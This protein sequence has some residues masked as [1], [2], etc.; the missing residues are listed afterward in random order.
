MNEMMIK[1]VAIAKPTDSG[2]I[3]DKVKRKSSVEI[4]TVSS[5]IT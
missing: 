2:I 1:H 5:E 4:A 3:S